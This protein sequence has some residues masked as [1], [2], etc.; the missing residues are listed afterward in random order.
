MVLAFAVEFVIIGLIL[1]NQSAVAAELSNAS[2]LSFIKAAS[3]PI[4]LSMAEL[5]R[6]PLAIAV[7]TQPSWNIKVVA[8]VGVLA[9][10]VVTAVNL[11]VIGWNTYD[12]R[13]C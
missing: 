1:T 11:S 10:V 12:P 6:V 2:W 7:R 9:A 3:L 5:A 4:A 8:T 13:A